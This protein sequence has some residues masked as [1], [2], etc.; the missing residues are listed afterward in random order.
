MWYRKRVP[1][2]VQ[3]VLVLPIS[4]TASLL[5]VALAAVHRAGRASVVFRALPT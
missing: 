5:F 4:G 3:T 2:T 1:K